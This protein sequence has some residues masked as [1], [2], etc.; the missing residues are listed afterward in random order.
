L[1][2]AFIPPRLQP[3]PAPSTTTP[4]T[5]TPNAISTSTPK[6]RPTPKTTGQEPTGF[7]AAVK[8]REDDHLNRWPL[9]QEI[10]GL[11][12]TSP[13]AWSARIGLY[14]EWGTGKTSVLEFIAA[15]A[16][17]NGHIVINFNPWEH[18]TKEALWRAFVIAVFKDPALAKAKGARF[19]QLKSLA[20]KIEN[21]SKFIGAGISAANE[22][23]GKAAGAGLD[24]VKSFFSFTAKDLS[25]IRSSLGSRR[26]FIL[27][28]DLDR[29]APELVPEILF[30]LKELM[31]LPGFSF[32]CAFDPIVVGKVLRR[33]HPGFGDGLKFL[34]KIIDYP[35]WLP[36]PSPEGLSRLDRKSVV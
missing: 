9:A 1:G 15:I 3:S 16:R 22:K 4:V 18:S 26:V 36:P 23:A 6:V 13:P 2:T 19:A 28:D 14:G 33:Y 27:I 10:F 34:E 5:A 35:R 32:V 21:A 24:L 20:G 17:E 31:D 7:D 11:V 30:A 29:T 8:R 25:S 12:T